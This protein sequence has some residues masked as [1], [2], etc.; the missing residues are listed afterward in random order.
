M[1]QDQE[2]PVQPPAT[3]PMAPGGEPS[4][5]RRPLRPKKPHRKI[6]WRVSALVTMLLLILLVVIMLVVLLPG[7]NR[8]NKLNKVVNGANNVSITVDSS[9]STLAHNGWGPSDTENLKNLL[10]DLGVQQYN[11]QVNV[12]SD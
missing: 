4:R 5:G 9:N 12:S 7:N 6:S 3:A 11:V 10:K 2:P 8:Y 1:P